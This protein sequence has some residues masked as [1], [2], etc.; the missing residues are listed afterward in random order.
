MP[1]S[2][3]LKPELQRILDELS[4]RER[5]SRSAV[6]HELLTAQL[7]RRQMHPAE[8]LRRALAGAPEGL[9]IARRQPAKPDKR[10][11]KR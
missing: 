10:A 7:R 4:R 8:A 3:R 11:W 2:V 6:I 5:K 1:I 9:N